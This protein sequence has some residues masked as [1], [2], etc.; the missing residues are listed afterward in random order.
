M[1][2]AEVDHIGRK[3]HQFVCKFQLT[4]GNSSLNVNYD[5]AVVSGLGNGISL[6]LWSAIARRR[7]GAILYFAILN[8]R[9]QLPRCRLANQRAAKILGAPGDSEVYYIIRIID[10]LVHE[11]FLS[12]TRPD[13]VYVHEFEKAKQYEFWQDAEKDRRKPKE[14]ELR[15]EEVVNVV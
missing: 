10:P 6:S 7:A 14:G 8:L 4:A 11:R 9:S 2:D 5:G 15:I 12:E 1:S 3:Q 13:R